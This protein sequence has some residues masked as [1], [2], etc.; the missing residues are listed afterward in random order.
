MADI[1][2]QIHLNDESTLDVTSARTN[3]EQLNRYRNIK[4]AQYAS[5]FVPGKKYVYEREGLRTQLNVLD[6][7]SGQV[8]NDSNSDVVSVGNDE[9]RRRL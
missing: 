5:G 4:S 1:Y 3:F 9:N 2:N 7:D 8:P 6:R